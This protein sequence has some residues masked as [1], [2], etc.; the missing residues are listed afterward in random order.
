MSR[1]V[2]AARQPFPKRVD[3]L[4]PAGHSGIGS[5]PVFC[6]EQ[7]GAGAEHASNLI[8]SRSR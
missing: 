3:T 6:K 2:A 5:E 7:P 1:K 4:L 8:Q